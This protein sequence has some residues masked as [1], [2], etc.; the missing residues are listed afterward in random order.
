MRREGP[1]LLPR[2]SPAT[3]PARPARPSAGDAARPSAL[4]LP[5]RVEP[6]A[7]GRWALLSALA[8]L[9]LLE[10]LA[11]QRAGGV[12][13]YPLDD[14]YIH[15]AIAEQIARG[16]YGVND[17]EYASAGSSILY[18][19]LLVPF[20][21]SELQRWLPLVWN[22]LGLSAA[23]LLWGR[24]LVRAGYGDPGR[25]WLGRVLAVL[26]PVGLNMAGLAFLGMEHM[27][28]VAVTLMVLLG[29]QRLVEE[30]RVDAMLVAGILLGPLLRFEAVALSGIACLAMLLRGHVLA[31]L[32]AGILALL[33]VALFGLFLMAL[34][35]DPVPNSVLAKIGLPRSDEIGL[36]ERQYLALLL[37]LTRTPGKILLVLLMAALVL[38]LVDRSIRRGPRLLLWLALVLTGTAQLVFGS[39]G[40]LNRYEIYAVVFM[41]GAAAALLAPL[42]DAP[43]GGFVRFCLVA[44]MAATG[45][46]YVRDMLAVGPDSAAAIRFQQAQMARFAQAHVAAPVAVND[47]GRV[48]WRNPHYVLDLWGLASRE[49]LETRLWRNVPGWAGPLAERHG[50]VLAMIYDSWLGEAVAPGWVKLGELRLTVPKGFAADSRVSFYAT[51]ADHVPA[52]RRHLAAFVPTLPAGAAF[53]AEPDPPGLGPAAPAA[54]PGEEPAPGPAPA[55]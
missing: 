21:G 42:S 6:P 4:G 25:R 28:H 37:N 26:G 10:A 27:L 20:A 54:P 53:V 11:W 48:A 55:P 24:V 46:W 52:L 29:L 32:A 45:G 51:D 13:E 12:L 34:G 30:D 18:P 33:P 14:V 9:A 50:V 15:L 23:A 43:R 44:V 3:L 35:L 16:S 39:V 8:F 19:V 49:A 41:F 17:G 7:F 38:P 47:L 5:I 2:P 36:L 22:L 1:R 40:W 31:A